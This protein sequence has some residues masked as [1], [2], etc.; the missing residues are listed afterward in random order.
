MGQKI[1]IPFIY[2]SRHGKIRVQFFRDNDTVNG[3]IKDIILRLFLYCTKKY[4]KFSYFDLENPNVLTKRI[5][6]QN[7]Y[8]I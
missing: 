3:H 8:G 5:Q 1:G 7:S 4:L 6:N 2:L